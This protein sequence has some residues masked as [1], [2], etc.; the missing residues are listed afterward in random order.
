MLLV[1]LAAAAN[2]YTAPIG[3]NTTSSPAASIDS[4]G[5][6]SYTS[7][8]GLYK[9]YAKVSGSNVISGVSGDSTTYAFGVVS[10][11]KVWNA[12]TA[13]S[14]IS[15][16]SWVKL[17]GISPNYDM[18]TGTHDTKQ[19]KGMQAGYPFQFEMV[20]LRAAGSGAQKAVVGSIVTALQT[21]TYNLPGIAYIGST[22][23][24][25]A[26]TFY[27]GGLANNYAPLRFY[28]TSVY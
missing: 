1:L 20:A 19:R 8:S 18:A 15:G 27:R 25:Y 14:G 9:N 23:S 4:S 21:D 3:T 13:S 17:D 28:A 2:G 6:Y 11:E 12:A 24:T 22:D 5:N 26:A 10:L 16:G 7:T